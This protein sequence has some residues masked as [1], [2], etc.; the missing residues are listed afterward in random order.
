MA[1][2]KTYGIRGLLEWHG[3]VNSNG[4]RMK[5]DFTNGSVTAYGVAPATFTTKNAMTQHVIEHS[6]QYKSGRITLV[7]SVEI[8]DPKPVEKPKAAAAPK[9]EEPVEQPKAVETEEPAIEFVSEPTSEKE[10]GKVVK[11]ADKNEA[12]EWLKEHFA[13]KKYSATKLRT[14][15]AFEAACAECGVTFEIGE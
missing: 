6:D 15:K 9:A 10:E 3:E 12:I 14:D 11:V 13:E 7:R 8:P 4:I 2:I 1:Y 5:V